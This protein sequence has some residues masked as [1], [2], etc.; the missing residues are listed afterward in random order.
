VASSKKQLVTEYRT[1]AIL[2]A[3]RRVFGAKGYDRATID[4]VARAAGVAKGTV[5]L[6]YSSK[7]DLYWEALKQG[8]LELRDDTVRRVASAGT[9]DEKVEAFIRSKLEYF[10]AHRD[11]FRLYHPEF[12]KAIARSTSFQKPLDTVYL[13][14]VRLLEDALRQ[15]VASGKIRPV[16]CTAAAF[17][18][19][20][21]TWGLVTQRLRGWS[22]TS[23]D[24]DVSFAL[25]LL[26]RGMSIR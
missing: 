3:A 6:Y 21:I 8:I 11:F 10:D 13:E 15:A 14:Q 26:W 7:R 5:Y 24:E 17:A 16:Q 1:A 4:D 12:R 9:L 2:R 20:D 22:D 18:V 23:I 25:D 19:F